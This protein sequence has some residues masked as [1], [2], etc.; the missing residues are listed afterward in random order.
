MLT[1]GL[2]AFHGDSSAC[3]L[4]DGHLI[5]AVEEERFSRVK[6]AAGFPEM[7]I[8]YCLGTAGARITDL[9]LVAIN[10]DPKA[11]RGRKLL[12]ALRDRPPLRYFAERVRHRRERLDL[13]GHFERSLGSLNDRVRIC[14]VEHHRSHLASSY[15][16]SPFDHAAVLSVDGFGDF[17]SCA[18]GVAK[19]LDL[20]IQGEVLF[21]HSLG[22]FYQALTQFL[23]FPH[24]GDEYKV[25]GLAPYGQPA[26]MEE[27]R[28]L[29]AI[30]KRGGF[31]L[32]LDY[33]LH[34]REKMSFQ[35]EGGLPTFTR[36][37]SPTLEAMLGPERT[38]GAELT[39]RHMDIACSVQN[40]FEDVFLSIVSDLAETS[41]EKNV[42]LAG[43][44]AMNSVAVG[45]IHE[46]SGFEEVFVQPGAGDAGG[47]LG[48]AV[49]AELSVNGTL[50]RQPMRHAGWGPAFD[51]AYMS[52]LIKK[53]N[54]ELCSAGIECAHVDR[55]EDLDR[56]IAEAIAG[57][58]VVGWFQGRMEWGPRA[59][60]QRSIL[61][62]PRRADMKEILNKKIKLRESFRPFAPSVLRD[63]VDEW[64]EMDDDVPF[65]TKVL[66]IRPERRS[67]I[68]AVTH[69][70]GT[71]R[72]QTVSREHNVRYYEL[73]SR[74]AEKT[75][76]PM[77]LN[78]SF[79]ENEPIVCRPEEAI[80]CFL[81]TRMDWLVINRH[82]FRRANGG[83]V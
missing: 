55:E 61:A 38:P 69:V 76:V 25:M 49:C 5:A 58:D 18:W 36:L 81:R 79:N 54:V 78:T 26:Y 37:Y 44:C 83:A 9:D 20:R 51:D 77:L 2:N 80:D 14:R 34:H 29:V 8:A 59:L 17:C 3:I 74:F 21:P 10:S 64:F 50:P 56:E 33:F 57:G 7:A 42:C 62:D 41:G 35:W 82:V 60:G 39:Q 72:L 4:E 13:R 19:G 48:A 24:Y 75:G 67:K 27:M 73:I 28:R 15:Y 43:G 68:P 40:R 1:L 70:D 71:G 46:R 11:R 6:H 31:T 30:G 47:A 22:V 63:R 23:G 52:R 45:K 12:Y 65:M 53:R 16:F 32:N 66:R